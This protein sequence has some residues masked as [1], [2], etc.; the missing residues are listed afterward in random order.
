MDDT[1]IDE[2]V[3]TWG[4]MGSSWGVNASV[5]RVHAL[6]IITEQPWCLD[7]ICSRLQISK[8]NGSTCLKEL[9][10]WGVVRKV[11][12]AGERREFFLCEPDPWQML[13]RIVAERK[14]REFDP[15][16]GSLRATLE[17]AGKSPGG[18]AL[19]RL[20]AMEKMLATFD[21][22]AS[23]LLADESQARALLSLLTGKG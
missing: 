18:I 3:E 21:R 19:E 15:V 10:G 22:I 2:F 4:A 12:L 20:K 1:I 7:D 16:L 9:R 11:L 13:F 6:L 17:K 8:G 5:A 14:K 23:T